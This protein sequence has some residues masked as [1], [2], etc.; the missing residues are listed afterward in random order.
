MVVVVV[1]A[2]AAAAAAETARARQ[3]GGQRRSE[4]SEGRVVTRWVARLVQGA[5]RK[6]ASWPAGQ[7]RPG[8]T[9]GEDNQGKG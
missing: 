6:G 4:R 2:A 9:Q 1:V 3:R 7:T 8:T 5:R